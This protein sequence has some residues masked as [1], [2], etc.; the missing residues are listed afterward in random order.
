MDK[1]ISI[2]IN[3]SKTKIL[4]VINNL[5]LSPTILELILAPI[6]FEVK[7]L[8]E[9]ELKQDLTNQEN[10]KIVEKEGICDD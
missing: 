1:T 7:Q 5:G 10:N 3:E 9:N 4:D 8:A 6:Y 2:L